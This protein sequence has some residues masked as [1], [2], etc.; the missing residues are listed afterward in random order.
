[1]KKHTLV[2][3]LT[4]LLLGC[5]SFT[6]FAGSN[7]YPAA[8]CVKWDAA[9]PTPVLNASRIYNAS[10][11]PMYVDCLAIRDDFDGFLHTSAVESSWLSAIDGHLNTC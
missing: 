9:Q 7:N 8:Q 11:L 2:H 5:I 1:M 6:A 4:A 3:S 10:T